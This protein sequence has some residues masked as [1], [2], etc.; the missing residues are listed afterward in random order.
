METV[1]FQ[2]PFALWA[3]LAVP[4]IVGLRIFGL[5]ASARATL[6][7]W[8]SGTLGS[9]TYGVVLARSLGTAATFILLV[10]ALAMPRWGYAVGPLPLAGRDLV[11]VVDVSRSMLAED[12]APN[13]LER[14]RADLLDLLAAIEQR[15][16]YRVGLVAFAGAARTVAPLT[17]A[18]DFVRRALEQLGPEDV[19]PGGS[20]LAEGL[21]EALGLFDEKTQNFRDVLLVSD[22]DDLGSD[23]EGIVPTCRDEGLSIYAIVRGDPNHGAEVPVYEPDGTRTV[24][25]YQGQVVRSRANGALL[26]R[27]AEQTGGLFVPAYTS[28]IDLRQLLDVMMERQPKQVWEERWGPRPLDRFIWALLPALLLLVADTLWGTVGASSPWRRRSFLMR[29]LRRNTASTVG[30]LAL[31]CCLPMLVAAS[32]T[33]PQPPARATETRSS[34]RAAQ[35]SVD[36]GLA[37]WR[38]GRWDDAAEAFARAASLAPDWWV[39]SY[40]LGVAH[41]VS[42]RWQESIRAFQGAR[43]T[44]PLAVHPLLNYCIGTAYLRQAEAALIAADRA[45]ALAALQQAVLYLGDSVEGFAWATEADPEVADLLRRL[46]PTE[47]ADTTGCTVQELKGNSQHNLE[48]AKKLLTRLRPQSS[49]QQNQPDQAG[50]TSTSPQQQE[51]SRPGEKARRADHLREPSGK[52]RQ[53]EHSSPNQSKPS[54]QPDSAQET[55]HRDQPSEARPEEPQAKGQEHD[56]GDA[57]QELAA[58]M[59]RLHERQRFRLQERLQ[60]ER[61]RVERDW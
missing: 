38:E 44:A 49:A 55:S 27:L 26:Q 25:R 37:Y 48:I 36:L 17:E 30:V 52:E 3:L 18:Y 58:Q 31:A 9:R 39:P 14:T 16:G 57:Q 42:R 21:R 15:G 61:F 12:V 41:A 34:K 33:G 20:L 40:E 24:L 47:Q 35:R 54:H 22:G 23:L 8:R 32:A 5:R 6:A 28:Q 60:V 59:R 53:P 7:F 4:L 10:V 13:R 19:Y 11:L 45:G 29:S 51:H 56:F 50:G 2:Y 46:A 1:S 43:Q